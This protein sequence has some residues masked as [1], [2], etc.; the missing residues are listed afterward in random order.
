MPPVET[1]PA[2]MLIRAAESALRNDPATLAWL[3]AFAVLAIV[4]ELVWKR[5]RAG[6]VA[7]PGA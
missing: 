6:Q 2:E 7:A 5:T 4:I 1:F 3:A